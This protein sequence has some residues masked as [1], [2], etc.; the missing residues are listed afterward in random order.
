MENKKLQTNSYEIIVLDDAS[1]DATENIIS[2]YI[3]K[4]PNIRYKNEVQ[5]GIPY[6]RNKINRLCNGKYI[7]VTD[8]DDI[9]FLTE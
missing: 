9:I 1:T 8:D 6:S 7:I 4:I 2:E 5:S 3:S